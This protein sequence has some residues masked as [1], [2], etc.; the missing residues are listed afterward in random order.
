MGGFALAKNQGMQPIS[1]KPPLSAL[2]PLSKLFACFAPAYAAPPLAA[3]LW[4]PHSGSQRPGPRGARMKAAIG[5][6]A[7]FASPRKRL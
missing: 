4:N 6:A 3:V 5:M 2:S 1:I 7:A